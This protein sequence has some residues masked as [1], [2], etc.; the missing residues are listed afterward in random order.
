MPKSGY[1]RI[2]ETGD[3]QNQS[4][5]FFSLAHCDAAEGWQL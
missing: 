2:A 3:G 1:W 5:G 4:G